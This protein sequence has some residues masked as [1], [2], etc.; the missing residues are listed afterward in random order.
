MSEAFLAEVQYISRNN[1]TTRLV[2]SQL[3]S[4]LHQ[5][6]QY[7]EGRL[8]SIGFV[9]LPADGTYFLVADFRY[10]HLTHSFAQSSR[11]RNHHNLYLQTLLLALASC[12]KL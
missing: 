1:V 4:S 10:E 9:V 12:F 11:L 7:L 6:R 2:C 8:K 3:G 5:K